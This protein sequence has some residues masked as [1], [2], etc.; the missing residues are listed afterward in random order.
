[1]EP[2]IITIDNEA[3]IAM[4]ICN[5]DTVGNRYVA[6]RYHYVQQ[7]TAL[8][9]DKFEWISTKYQLAGPLTKSG[10][11]NSFMELWKYMLHECNL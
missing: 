1:M 11:V 5:K 6:R 9:E 10:S 2:V 3:A 4:A 8:E 7:G